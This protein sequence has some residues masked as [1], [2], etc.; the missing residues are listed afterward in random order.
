MPAPR[1]V[2][3]DAELAA[4]MEAEECWAAQFDWQRHDLEMDDARAAGDWDRV[5]MLAGTAAYVRTRFGAPAERLRQL[6]VSRAVSEA[7]GGSEEDRRFRNADYE[8][9]SCQ[10]DIRDAEWRLCELEA[11][12]DVLRMAESD[13]EMR[14]YDPAG[15]DELHNAAW[16]LA[17]CDQRIAKV[18]T[19]L[20]HLRDRLGWLETQCVDYAEK[21]EAKL[22]IIARRHAMGSVREPKPQKWTVLTAHGMRGRSRAARSGTQ[23]HQGSRRGTNSCASTRGSPDDPDGDLPP[24][25]PG[26]GA[27]WQ[28][29]LGAELKP[30]Y[31]SGCRLLLIERSSR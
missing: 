21:A 17:E 23:A 7:C 6:E 14:A 20:E 1:D 25:A 12:R 10:L 15:Q 9:D 28:A 8:Y 11:Q 2:A 18:E 26:P 3:R 16:Q 27:R 5:H 13:A 22:E 19:E 31:V 24:P 29:L 30:E 4:E